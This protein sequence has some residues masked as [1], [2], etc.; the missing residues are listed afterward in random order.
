MA[1][2]AIDP[3]A[4]MTAVKSAIEMFR[5]GV[6]LAKEANE[7]S[8]NSGAKAAA[9]ESLV[10][11]ERAVR[12]AEAEIAKSLGYHLCKCKFP[13]EIMLSEGHE[14]EFGAE[15]FRCPSCQ[16]QEPSEQWFR[17]MREAQGY[18]VQDW[19]DA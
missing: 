10:A 4:A 15:V 19:P 9:A 7:L 18:R 2:M 12:L 16:K 13:P 1:K 6:A 3:V 17:N 8:G 11:A 5:G 14:H